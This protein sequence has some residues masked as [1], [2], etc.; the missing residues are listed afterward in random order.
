MTF[1]IV[2]LT[3][4][5]FE[6]EQIYSINICNAQIILEFVRGFGIILLV[7]AKITRGNKNDLVLK[8]KSKQITEMEKK[9]K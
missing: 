1:W 4:N 7:P 3:H 5:V 6:L 8:T 2:E 9:T